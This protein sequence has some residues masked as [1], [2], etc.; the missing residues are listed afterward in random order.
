MGFSLKAKAFVIILASQF[1]KVMGLQF[2]ISSVFLPSLGMIT[3]AD[4]L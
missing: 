4:S 3:I 1:D 2:L